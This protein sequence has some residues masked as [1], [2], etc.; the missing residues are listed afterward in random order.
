MFKNA[1][2]HNHSF[3]TGRICV[4]GLNQ[5]LCSLVKGVSVIKTSTLSNGADIYGEDESLVNLYFSA[6]KTTLL[7]R[8]I[9]VRTTSASSIFGAYTPS[10]LIR[11]APMKAVLK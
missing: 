6:T 10:G 8:A 2:H 5:L 1:E 4:L 9:A 11:E 3:K 7:A